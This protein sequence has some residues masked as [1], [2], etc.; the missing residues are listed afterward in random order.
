VAKSI[1]KS[2]A[3]PKSTDK[4]PTAKSSYKSSVPESAEARPTR[5][6]IEACAYQIYVESG[7]VQG[8]ELDNWLKAER[9]LREKYSKAVP[10]MKARTA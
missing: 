7:K 4:S 9:D 1:D 10:I 8:R 5:E 6:E 2:F 3:T